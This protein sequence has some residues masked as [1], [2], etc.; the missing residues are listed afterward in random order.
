MTEVDY[1][2]VSKMKIL[3][4]AEALMYTNPD[5]AYFLLSGIVDPGELTDAEKADYGYLIAGYHSDAGKKN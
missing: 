1:L 5:C 3:K 2:I 4:E